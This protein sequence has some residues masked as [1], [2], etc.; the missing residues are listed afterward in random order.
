MQKHLIVM[1]YCFSLLLATFGLSAEP[2]TKPEPRITPGQAIVPPKMRRIWGEL[3]SMDL[4]SRTG[5]FRNQSTD[6][7]VDF[8]VMPYAELLHHATFG[9][10]EDFIAGERA[11]FRLHEDEQGVWRHLTY[12]QDEMNFLNNHKEWYW[13]D[14]IDSSAGKLTC[15]QANADQSF[16]REKDVIV[17]VDSGTKYWREG[18][19]VSLADL[20]PGDRMQ[21]KARGLGKGTGNARVAWHLFLDTSSL[22]MF[23]AEQKKVH[24]QRMQS[25]GFPGYVDRV[26]QADGQ[27]VDLT[28]FQEGRE[29][30]ARMKPGMAVRLAL[31]GADRT[32]TAAVVDGTITDIRMQGVLGKVTL[33]VPAALP[34]GV[35]PQSVVRVGAPTLFE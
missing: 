1:S 20:K 5:K 32:P 29:W 17:N 16:V 8:E 11:I 19:A 27:R 12:I 25:Q 30:I 31:T 33:K 7:I 24:A 9:D 4:A 15:H 28:L 23:Q 21:I 35:A 2:E 22:E 3:V 26:H 34:A 14:S 10:L 18:K 13:I 6:E